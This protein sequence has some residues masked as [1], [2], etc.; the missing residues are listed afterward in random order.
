MV[1][2]AP[3]AWAGLHE[4]NGPAAGALNLGLAALPGILVQF[5]LH[6]AI[7]GLSGPRGFVDRTFHLL[8][9]V[10]NGFAGNLLYLPRGFFRPTFNLIFVNA[11]E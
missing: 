9:G 11:H 3:P 5:A 2:A 4:L 10:A 7:L 8:R 1:S 6:V